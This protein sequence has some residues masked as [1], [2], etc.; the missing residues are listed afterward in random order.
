MNEEFPIIEPDGGLMSGEPNKN[1]Y[2]AQTVGAACKATGGGK[3]LDK[4]SDTQ[5]I[6]T[7]LDNSQD[8]IY[9]KDRHSRF[10]L[11]SK[12]H[13]HQFGVSD[14]KELMGKSD[15]DF[16]PEK[17]YQAA[18]EDEERIMA[19]G[20]PI[21]GRVEKL[22]KE[23]GTTVW[24][25]ASKYPLYGDAGEIVGTWGTSRNITGLKETELELERVNA[26]LAE[27][28]SKLKELSIID[29]LSGLYNR[30]NFY[31]ILSKMARA[32]TRRRAAGIETGFC[33]AILDVDSFKTVNDSYG[34]II[35]DAV[36]RHVAELI[37]TNIRTSDFAFRYGGDEFSI[38]F[39]DFSLEEA[40]AS[41]KNLCQIVESYPFS[42]KNI[43]IPLTLSIGV[44][45]YDP[46]KTTHLMIQEADNNLYE[47]KHKGRNQT[48]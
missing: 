35:G 19:T 21:V 3:W 39:T 37:S 10:I 1:D 16:Y 7:I 24:F 41:C 23:D 18:L 28:N 27:A 38:I 25:S 34:H 48:T 17:F 32:Y 31:D 43:T 29:D 11:N 40:R 20:E 13:A 44:S 33:L 4:L 22:E 12:A 30:R 36:I 14:P 42:N 6:R 47:S 45:A 46:D 26:K 8:T 2:I 5:I 9:F 15:R